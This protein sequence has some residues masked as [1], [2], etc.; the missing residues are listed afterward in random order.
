MLV[1][2]SGTYPTKALL[3]L[4]AVNTAAAFMALFLPRETGGKI[5]EEVDILVDIQHESE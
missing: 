1:A 4:G 2:S 3:V 5:L